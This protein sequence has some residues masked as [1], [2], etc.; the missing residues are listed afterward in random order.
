MPLSTTKW[1]VEDYHRM[2]DAGI[3]D[4]RHVELLSGEII[5]MPPEGPLHANLNSNTADY[6]RELLKNQA[7]VREGH[8]VTLSDDSEPEPDIAIVQRLAAGYGQHHPYPENIFWLIE[9]SDSSLTRDLESKSKIYAEANIAE[10]WVV[11]LRKLRLVV[12]QSPIDGVYSSMQTCESGTISPLSF[13][14]VQVSI[15]LLLKP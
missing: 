6:L 14:E 7:Q 15:D 8:P 11:N 13:P 12:F 1:T 9:F 5:E 2:I 4:D 3:L 10:Y